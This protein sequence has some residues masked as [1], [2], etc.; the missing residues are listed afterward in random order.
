MLFR[1]SSVPQ[2]GMK[3]ETLQITWHSKEGSKNEPLL[4]VDVHP[5]LP[6]LAT[7]GA[8]W[9]VKLWKIHEVSTDTE[10]NVSIEYICTLTGHQK[11]VN[12]LRF[13]PNG[14]CLATAGDGM[15]SLIVATS[16]FII[17]PHG[18]ILQIACVSSGL[19]CLNIN[20]IPFVVNEISSAVH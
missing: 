10:T 3:A 19:L 11:T 17:Q 4:S 7:A 14:E 9:E 18:P 16:S 15:F 5:T 2:V 12:V 6:I 1:L 20:G 8:D 13:S